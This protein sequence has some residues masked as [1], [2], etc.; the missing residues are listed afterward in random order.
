MPNGTTVQQAPQRV[1]ELET[2]VAK[3]EEQDQRNRKLLVDLQQ[4]LGALE[5]RLTQLELEPSAAEPVE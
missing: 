1:S 3:L 2:R 4:R 5:Q